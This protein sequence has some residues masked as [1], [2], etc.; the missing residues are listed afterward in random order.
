MANI[1][2]S[3]RQKTENIHTICH[4]LYWN[5]PTQQLH[6]LKRVSVTSASEIPFCYRHVAIQPLKYRGYNT[7]KQRPQGIHL[8]Q[9]QR[10]G[11]DCNL[12]GESHQKEPR[13][14]LCRVQKQMYSGGGGAATG[15]WVKPEGGRDSANMRRPVIRSTAHSPILS[16]DQEHRTLSYPILSYP[17]L[18]FL[19]RS[20]WHGLPWG[21]LFNTVAPSV[22]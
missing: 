11:T 14:L 16:C 5:C 12:L 18:S 2:W 10:C 8:A 1:L 13:R 4:L 17:I 20:T 7:V 22:A 3:L 15:L 21:P 6:C 9:Q 19:T